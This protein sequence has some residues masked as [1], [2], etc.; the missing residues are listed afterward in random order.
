MQGDS[1]LTFTPGGPGAPLGPSGPCGKQ[2]TRKLAV[3]LLR[4]CIDAPGHEI[5]TVGP[6]I[7]GSP[8]LPWIQNRN[9]QLHT[10]N[11]KLN[12]L[13]VAGLHIFL[14]FY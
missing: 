13:F 8:G 11:R 6:L 2:E 10:D 5:L 14:I 12:H 7:P 4:L 9:Q 1:K 3:C